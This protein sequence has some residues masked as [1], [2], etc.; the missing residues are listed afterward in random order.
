MAED[1]LGGLEHR[2][3]GAGLALVLLDDLA[4]PFLLFRR[5]PVGDRGLAVRHMGSSSLKVRRHAP[6][7]PKNAK[8]IKG[9]KL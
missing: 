7:P 1:L 2:H 3:G 6:E 9:A 5:A 8:H 4:Q